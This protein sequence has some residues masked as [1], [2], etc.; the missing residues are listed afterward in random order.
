MGLGM[1]ERA[2]RGEGI[3]WSTG[4]GMIFVSTAVAFSVRSGVWPRHALDHDLQ[5][6]SSLHGRGERFQ[7]FLDVR[8]PGTSWQHSSQ[9]QIPFVDDSA[10]CT[11]DG[12]ASIP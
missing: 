1:A 9:V 4:L 2:F 7:A 6:F 11:T 12:L 5:A 10:D 8:R 3:F